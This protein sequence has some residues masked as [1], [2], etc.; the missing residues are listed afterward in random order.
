M[1]GRQRLKQRHWRWE[2][3]RPRERETHWDLEKHWGTKKHLGKERPREINW[4]MEKETRRET[5]M[6]KDLKKRKG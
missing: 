4:L 1:T 3:V 5:V 2:R 6:L